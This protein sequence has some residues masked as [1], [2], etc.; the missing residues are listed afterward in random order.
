MSPGTNIGARGPARLGFVTAVSFGY[1]FLYIPIV[2]LVLYSFNDSR[3][4][5]VWGGFSTRWYGA[6]FE[7]QV[8][9]TAA[10]RSLQVAVTSASLATLVGLA[11]GLALVR[12]T[13]MRRALL[14]ACFGSLLVMPDVLIGLSMLLLFVNLEQWVGWPAGRGL[15]TVSLAHLTFA[16]AYVAVVVRARLM[17]VDHSIEEAARD[18]G[19]RPGQ[20]FWLVTV[21]LIRP[22]LISGWLLAFTL[23][24]DDLVVASFVSGPGSSTLPMVIYS[25][26]RLGVTPEVNAL[27]TLLIAAVALGV[28]SAAL[29]NRFLS[30][31]DSRP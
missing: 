30:R 26:V 18:L 10:W 31:P 27:A 15:T 28:I 1:A 7:N 12:L 8:L 29:I 4:V 6:L 19:A 13:G 9:L 2:L 22:A 23:S 5:T 3:L 24:L 25:S 17:Q 11:A 14:M 20:A 16:S 21:P